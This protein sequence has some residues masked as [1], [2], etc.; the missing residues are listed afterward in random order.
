MRSDMGERCF[1]VLLKDGWLNVFE[2]PRG[3]VFA[4]AQARRAGICGVF[5]R[6]ELAEEFVAAQ[7]RFLAPNSP[8]DDEE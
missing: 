6:R 3:E 4:A 1:L 7:R 8:A 2:C 5:E